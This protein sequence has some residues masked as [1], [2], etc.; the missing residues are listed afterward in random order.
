MLMDFKQSCVFLK[1]LFLVFEDIV[2]LD[3]EAKIEALPHIFFS[4]LFADLPKVLICSFIIIILQVDGHSF[5]VL[6]NVNIKPGEFNSVLD[7]IFDLIDNINHYFH[8]LFM[9]WIYNFKTFSDFLC[10][11]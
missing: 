10:I 2:S 6:A 8:S 5:L 1:E 4:E 9:G 7:F 3:A 11:H